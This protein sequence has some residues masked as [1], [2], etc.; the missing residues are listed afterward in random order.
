M[1]ND[2][3]HF[4]GPLIHEMMQLL[5]NKQ[6]YNSFNNQIQLLMQSDNMNF[7]SRMHSNVSNIETYCF[8]ILNSIENIFPSQSYQVPQFLFRIYNA[9]LFC[10]TEK[11]TFLNNLK[12]SYRFNDLII[13]GLSLYLIKRYFH[14]N[15]VDTKSLQQRSP[16]NRR[17]FKKYPFI[18]N[19][20]GFSTSILGSKF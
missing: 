12:N 17:L 2:I 8:N 13:R 11:F 20:E 4:I 14:S 19:R 9:I 7:S 3:R 18:E 5:I 10:N 6:F 15:R 16:F 1:L